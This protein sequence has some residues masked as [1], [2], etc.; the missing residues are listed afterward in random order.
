MHI[1]SRKSSA[2]TQ[3]LEV[4]NDLLD[5]A[6]ANLED[7]LEG[8]DEKLQLIIGEHVT[9][10]ESVG[11]E[12]RLIREER[13]S[14][15]KCLENCAQLSQHINRIQVLANHS[16]S[17]SEQT[18]SDTLSERI[19]NEGL[20]EC[21]NSPARTT[22]KVEGYEKQLFVQLMDRSKIANISEEERAD[23]ARLRD[24]LAA[25][26]QGMDI[27]SRAHEN[28]KDNVSTIE[29]YAT[30]DAVQFMVST[31]EKTIHGKNRGLGWRTRQGGGHISDD[32]FQ[33]IARS[34]ASITIPRSEP[35]GSSPPGGTR[36][37]PGVDVEPGKESDSK[38]KEQYGRGFKLTPQCVSNA[39]PSG[40]GSP[41]GGPSSSPEVRPFTK[42]T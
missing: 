41:K 2:T 5:N 32:S 13:L 14:M 20:Q 18:D 29:N 42:S 33:Q 17:R 12:V 26:R 3:S 39:P 40:T 15:V 1:S 4:Y 10:S 8:I 22:L 25:T 6:K 11:S 38:F 28:L 36:F 23:I 9:E 24:E 19:T 27:C 30:G 37:V 21:K 34:L 31:S 35:R 7:R 16:S